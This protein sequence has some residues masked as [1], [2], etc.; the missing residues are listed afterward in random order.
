ME[1]GI[2]RVGLSRLELLE[3]AGCGHVLQ[4]RWSHLGG[5]FKGKGVFVLK[6][7]LLVEYLAGV[8]LHLGV[9]PGVIG[10]EPSKLLEG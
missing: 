5:A 6:S 9:L 4:T 1:G 2:L 3:L 10:V 7:G 8:V